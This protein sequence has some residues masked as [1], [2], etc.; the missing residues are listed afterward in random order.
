MKLKANK[1]HPD[2]KINVKYSQRPLAALSACQDPIDF[3]F[4]SKAPAE[5]LIKEH[6]IT[7]L[8]DT[9]PTDL[10]KQPEFKTYD[11]ILEQPTGNAKRFEC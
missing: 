8:V 2:K 3:L 4:A 5:N 11:T 9:V 1:N 7:G 6:A 10:D